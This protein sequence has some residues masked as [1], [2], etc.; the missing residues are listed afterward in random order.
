M[1][2]KSLV[3]LGLLSL[4][5]PAA[6]LADPEV[7]VAPTANPTFDNLPPAIPLWPK[8][9]PGSEGQSSPLEK[10]W[11]NYKTTWYSVISNI[12]TPAILPFLPAPDKA[13][14]CAIVVCPGGGHRFL[15]MEHEGYAV[16]KWLSEHGI[17]AFILEYRLANAPGSPYKVDVHA[18]MDAQRAIRFVRSRAAE[19]K[20]NPAAIGIMGFSAGGELAAL[21]ASRFDRP[22]RGTS[23]A[24]DAADCR[25]NFQAL[26]YP[27]LA[28]V[29]AP[30]TA[31]S[32]VAFLCGASDDGFGLTPGM[33]KYYL[34][35]TAA[36]VPAELH[37]YAHGGHGF[38]IRDKDMA[39]YSW[40]PLFL[41]WL[42]DSGFLAAGAPPGPK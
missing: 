29:K 30:P 41:T 20:I 1:N 22:V 28:A 12:N 42:R 39:V 3:T 38:G 15:A 9:A 21:A 37:V 31:N 8:A 5:A 32:P 25:P 17:A 7:H 34:A 35:L 4:L 36:G 27:G 16:G 6:A 14:G 19:W 18:L 2:A 13:T 11:E 24:I 26:F 10:R 33:V 40:M 23:D